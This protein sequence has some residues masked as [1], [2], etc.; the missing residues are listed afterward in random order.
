MFRS[1][2]TVGQ[3][4][5]GLFAVSGV[6]CIAAITRA[7]QIDDP[8][9]RRGLVWLLATSGGWA[10]FK[11]VFFLLESRLLSQAA[12]IIG[13]GIGFATVW[14]WLYF[15]SAYTGRNYHHNT[16]LRRAS[17]AIFLAVI[18][19]KVTNPVH[20]L[21]FTTNPETTP[22]AYFA[23]EHNV[24][25]WT[26]T[27]LSYVLAAV[28]LF[29]IFQLFVE[30]GYNTRPLSFLTLLIAIP[31]VVD[32][33][34]QLTPRIIN[35][36]YAPLGVAAFAV[37]VLF[38]FER[39]FLAVQGQPTD[40]DDMS[41][42]L[43]E[44][45]RVRDYSDAVTDVVPELDGSTGKPLAEVAPTVAAAVKTDDKILERDG[46]DGQRYYFVSSSTVSLGDT[47]V[48]LVQISDVT[49]TE[50]QRRKLAE[51]EQELDEQNELYRAVIDASFASV[52]RLDTEGRFIFVSPSVEEFLGYT[53]TELE[54]ELV[55][56]VQA[57]EAT[58][59]RAWDQMEVI[60][61]GESNRV[62]DF[63]LETKSGTEI[64]ADVRGVPIYDGSVPE[65]ERT[66]ADIVGI[67][68]MARDATERREREGLISVT[69]RVLRH[70]LRNKMTVI[71]SYANMLEETLDGDDADK[72]T[73]I[74]N[75][76]DQLLDLSESA[77][78]I[79]ENREL[80]PELEPLDI[81]P[82]IDRAVTQLRMQYPDASVTVHADDAVVARTNERIETALWEVIDNAA[83]HGGDPP[84]VDVDV[85]TTDRQVVVTVTD[86]GP[87]LPDMEREVLESNTETQLVHGDGLGLWL[88][89]WIVTS[90]NGEIDAEPSPDGTAVT[91]RLPKPT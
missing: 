37:G 76:A 21:Y 35:V 43:D 32:V 10:L 63:P 3:L 70:N 2:N 26:A 66:P 87:G 61:G 9:V 45:G 86:N 78:K 89:Y 68:L 72:A 65:G 54:G 53:P 15:C 67:Q 74:R 75:T 1:L 85:T 17:A 46:V 13:L 56:V 60:L 27:G 40:R 55:S 90:L 23:I 16:S 44:S 8:D 34:A 4:Y 20:G 14:A 91:V 6:L 47:G 29:M 81:V 69:N 71:T 36:I 50:R 77:Q 57:D 84:V 42:Y 41:I 22:F 11:T 49:Q 38:V 39:Q 18:S 48:E 5:V 52:F 25:H 33:V 73:Q 88:V 64:Y 28:G 82:I 83:K 79:D 51:R 31:V 19:V 12:Y 59:E 62:R 58:T 24:A 7:R 80:S 30:S